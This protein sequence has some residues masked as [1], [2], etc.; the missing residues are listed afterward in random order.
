MGNLSWAILILFFVFMVAVAIKFRNT[1]TLNQLLL[2]EGEELLFEENPKRIQFDRTRN[3]TTVIMRATIK[4]TNKRIIVGQR[5]FRK[6]D[7]RIYTIFVLG[8]LPN[9]EGVVQQALQ[10]GFASVQITLSDI[11]AKMDSKGGYIIDVQG[12]FEAPMVGVVTPEYLM[13]IYTS[14]LSGYEKAL[15]RKITVNH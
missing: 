2:D 13:R 14:N 4:I 9:G 5:F 15:N 10:D 1:K 8:A 3:R 12:S 7:A 11:V 6:P